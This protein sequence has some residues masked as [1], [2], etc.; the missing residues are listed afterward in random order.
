M[1][2]RKKKNLSKNLKMKKEKMN[3]WRMNSRIQRL[4]H[5][6]NSFRRKPM[7]KVRLVQALRKR[8]SLPTRKRPKPRFPEQMPPI[9]IRPN[10]KAPGLTPRSKRL[11]WGKSKNHQS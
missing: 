2:R 5:Q 4:P 10:K 8:T 9:K 11:W 1:R 3:K 6:K 7:I